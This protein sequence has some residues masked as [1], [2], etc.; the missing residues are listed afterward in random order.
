M[1]TA[2]SPKELRS[3]G[4]AS[5]PA[6]QPRKSKANLK[7]TD[8]LFA[9]ARPVWKECLAHPFVTGIGDG[10]LPIE[11]FQYYMLQDYV[12]LYDYAKVFALGAVKSKDPALMR[13][14]SQNVF[15]I[16]HGEMELH[17]AYMKRLGISEERADTVTA[18]LPNL[19]YTSYMLAEAQAGGPA[20]IVAS[21]LAC[22]WTYSDIG[23]TLA[24]IPGATEHP[25]YGEWILEYCGE[26]YQKSNDS[27]LALMNRLAEGLPEAQL[28]HLEDVYVNCVRLERGFWDMAWEMTP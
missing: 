11:K 5:I 13:E 9:A 10:S 6:D 4:G 18:A 7:F 14:F 24:R 12:C 19:S 21:I 28:Q 20:E 26:G 1:N 2:S 25:F 3:V 23:L 8:R 16:L 15:D 17:R 22:S 27:L